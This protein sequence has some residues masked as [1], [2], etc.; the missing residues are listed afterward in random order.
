M[1]IRVQL[2][3][4][5]I[6]LI[7]ED[8]GDATQ[9][10]VLSGGAEPFAL[11]DGDTL[12][13]QIDGGGTQTI[14]FHAID[15]VDV[16]DATLAEVLAVLG[17]STGITGAAA[18]G[19]AGAI[20]ITSATWGYGSSVQVT[21]G[22][23]N[24]V[25]GFDTA[26]HRG[27]NFVPVT[28][29]INRI[30]ENSEYG[31]PTDA[32]IEL[33]LHSGSG[34]APTLGDVEVRV[35]DALVFDGADWQA[36]WAGADTTPN[37]ATLRLV[38]APTGVFD[39]DTEYTVGVVVSTVLDDE[40]T[41]RTADNITPQLV[42]A[43]VRSQTFV[44]VVFNEAV[45]QVSP[46]NTDDALNPA[47]YVF[48]RAS[49]PSVEV[50]AYEVTPV[51]TRTVDV[52]VDTELSW[53][54]QYLLT[55]ANVAD[56]YGNIIVTPND[57]A[58]FVTLSQPWPAGRRWQLLEFIPQINRTEDVT[59]E[60]AR[61]IGCLQDVCDLLL[62]LID[63]WTRILDVDLA[64][65]KWL[66]WMLLDLGNPFSFSEL[67][68]VDKRRLLKVLV[69]MYREKGTSI[70]LRNVIRFFLGLEVTINIFNGLGWV[71]SDEATLDAADPP[72]LG[73]P[74]A[75]YANEL[76]GDATLGSGDSWLLYS[77]EIE[78]AVA[79]T[80]MQRQRITK[81]A[82]LMKPGHTHLLRIVEPTLPDEELDHLELGFSRLG[83][84]SYTG[85]WILH[86]VV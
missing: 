30:P 35:N 43:E 1:A 85:E 57:E 3:S 58:I 86:G 69:D 25:L 38:F 76:V 34:V 55:V 83:G 11:V 67:E 46:T 79:L 65:E 77:F 41:F 59:G 2:P 78:S 66:D 13:I 48:S 82:E 21:G 47:N 70:G 14:T 84:V 6:D 23:G 42:S 36:G 53:G 24:G 16:A 17:A 49:I 61:F 29:L 22:T 12:T 52:E 33:E 80:A 4:V 44:R 15:F 63:D 45:K 18:S 27:A 51:D 19:E 39:P 10:T 37:A 26:L 32:D 50:V 74:L 7:R 20:R 64:D 31:V 62:K 60:L 75:G 72:V 5:Q 9:G 54:C 68:V 81:I 8:L 71:L 73:D 28:Q 40:Y 56:V